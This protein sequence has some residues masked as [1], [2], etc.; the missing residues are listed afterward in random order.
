MH[1]T[2]FSSARCRAALGPTS[3]ALRAVRALQAVGINAEVVA[4]APNETKRGCA[5]GIE[6][7]CTDEPRVRATL[8]AA[9][10]S[11]SQYFKRG[12]T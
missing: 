5:F 2:D 6:F 3:A 7:A 11:V 1:I 12:N 9:R 8:R 10:V 4:L